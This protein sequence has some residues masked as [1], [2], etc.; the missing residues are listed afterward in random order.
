M[1]KGVPQNRAVVNKVQKKY[2]IWN[3]YIDLSKGN[4]TFLRET[5]TEK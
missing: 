2:F 5:I 3:S 1:R 4:P